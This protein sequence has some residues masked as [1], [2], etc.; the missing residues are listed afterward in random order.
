MA[1]QDSHLPPLPGL[2]S[3]EAI[4]LLLNPR[5]IA[6]TRTVVF[7]MQLYIGPTTTD[8]LIGCV[9]YF[10]E[11]GDSFDDVALYHATTT[12]RHLL[13]FCNNNLYFL[14]L[15]RTKRGWSG[16]KQ[17]QFELKRL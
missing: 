8:V 12:V 6:K 17:L 5:V 7:D 16:N 9:R 10:N 11:S 14:P 1:S 2:A 15:V 13:A 3:L 4:V